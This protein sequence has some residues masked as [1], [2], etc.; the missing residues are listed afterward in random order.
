M[1]RARARKNKRVTRAKKRVTGVKK[2][3]LVPRALPAPKRMV[4]SVRNAASMAADK[5]KA[6]GDRE[7]KLSYIGA[8]VAGAGVSMLTSSWLADR[9]WLDWISP[10]WQ[11]VVLT[12]LGATGSYV[13][14]RYDKPHLAWGLGGWAA[15]TAYYGGISALS[16]TAYEREVKQLSAGQ[17]A[18]QRPR[19]RN[20]YDDV[21][22]IEE[23]TE[24]LELAE[25]RVREL[26]EELAAA[27]AR[28][29]P[30]MELAAA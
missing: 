27:R 17:G 13:A 8:G 10:E 23:D 28:L 7:V 11:S 9:A 5:A 16:R 22:Y 15:G 1:A 2:R 20:A 21:D 18:S 24:Q 3:A 4:R 6:V 26:E 14:Y 30:E 19:P 29:T 12:G 25:D